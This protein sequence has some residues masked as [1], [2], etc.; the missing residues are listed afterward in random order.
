MHWLGDDRCRVSSYLSGSILELSSTL[1]SQRYVRPLTQIVLV[2]LSAGLVL[3]FFWLSFGFPLWSWLQ[4]NTGG[5]VL[6]ISSMSF[7][8]NN[9]AQTV[10]VTAAPPGGQFDLTFNIVAGGQS[11][12]VVPPNLF[13]M[14]SSGDTFLTTCF[15]WNSG[16]I[17]YGQTI[18]CM[19]MPSVAPLY[20]N[21]T[22]TPSFTGVG[23]FQNLQPGR[24]DLFFSGLTPMNFSLTAPAAQIGARDIMTVNYNVSGLDMMQYV[25]TIVNTSFLVMPTTPFFITCS[26]FTDNSVPFPG[27][28]LAIGRITTCTVTPNAQPAHLVVVFN[29]IKVSYRPL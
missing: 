18:Q 10:V 4:G 8:G 25:S 3:I 5:A 17:Y 2:Q 26:I 13:S 14:R 24:S 27:S 12:T 9:S 22:V 1:P 16:F 21:V 11:N 19:V 28:V 15:P 20:G 6:S 29:I 23:T 7:F